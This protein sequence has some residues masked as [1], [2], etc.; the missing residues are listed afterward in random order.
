M[1]N[2]ERIKF[3]EEVFQYMERLIVACVTNDE[4]ESRS[5]IETQLVE[6]LSK[7]SD[8]FHR[9]VVAETYRRLQE[10]SFDELQEIKDL[11]SDDDE[12][13]S[14]EQSDYDISETFDLDLPLRT[15]VLES[16]ISDKIAILNDKDEKELYELEGRFIYQGSYYL[17]MKRF[18]L[19]KIEETKI[20]KRSMFFEYV[21]EENPEEDKL[22]KIIDKELLKAL[23]KE[24]EFLFSIEIEEAKKKNK[25]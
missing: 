18:P 5:K 22:I 21:M 20:P 14:D 1:D 12:M 24:H 13:E 2:A 16:D 7:A 25:K 19:S 6:D 4:A 11:V 23:R 10:M 15:R 3:L 9:R 17:K 8:S